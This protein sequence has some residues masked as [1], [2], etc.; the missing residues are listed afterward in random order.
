MFQLPR[1]PIGFQMDY[2]ALLGPTHGISP[3][4]HRSTKCLLFVKLANSLLQD[5]E[6]SRAVKSPKPKNHESQALSEN[7]GL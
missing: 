1:N 4:K 7:A 3:H 6:Y 2:R 5:G